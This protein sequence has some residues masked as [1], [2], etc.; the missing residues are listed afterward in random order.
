LLA[1][2][3]GIHAAR[4]APSLTGTV[5]QYLLTPDGEVNGVLLQ[6]G[7]VVKF[8]PHLGASLALIAQPGDTVA[9]VGILGAGN[10]YGRAIK[11][12]TITNSKTGQS[13]VD[14]PPSTKPL[15]PDRRGLTLQPLSVSGS[16]AGLLVNHKGDVD[17]LILSGGEQVKF[18]PHN[19]ST[20]AMMLGQE[21]ETVVASGY[22]ARNAYGT[23]VEALSLSIAGQA[24]P[25]T[26]PGRP[27]S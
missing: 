18:P 14:R 3:A 4:Q 25:L 11:V 8:P 15:P 19:G 5:Q 10:Q 9:V 17:G 26:G 7:T 6:D 23:V 13:L 27:R 12:L 16:V 1:G 24:V 21:Q 20:V 22:G 2:L